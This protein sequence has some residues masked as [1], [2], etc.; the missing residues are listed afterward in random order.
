MRGRHPF[1]QPAPP[2][3][4]PLVHN[5]SALNVHEYDV[6][7]VCS[8]LFWRTKRELVQTFFE[9]LAAIGS[10]GFLAA[11]EVAVCEAASASLG[12]TCIVSQ[13]FRRDGSLSKER[14]RI[15]LD[16]L[17]RH[18]RIMYAGLDVRF[19]QPVSSWMRAAGPEVADAVFE[20]GFNMVTQTVGEFTPD[21]ALLH[22]SSITI[23]LLER[24]MVALQGRSLVGLP[25]FL[26]EASL[27]RFNL[28]GPAE[29]DLLRDFLLS[30]L[31]N[32]TVAVRKYQIARG[33]AASYRVGARL[34]AGVAVGESGELPRCGSTWEARHP[35]W[36]AACAGAA[37]VDEADLPYRLPYR[38]HDNGVIVRGSGGLRVFLSNGVG[39]RVSSQPCRTC[40]DW[41]VRRTMAL[42]CLTKLPSCLN[43][44]LCSCLWPQSQGA[45]PTTRRGDE[46]RAR[47][48]RRMAHLRA[49]GI[50][51]GGGRGGRGP[52]H[53]PP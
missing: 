14:W 16:I 48:Q 38:V 25:A 39:L 51:G 12:L 3:P 6:F 1:R 13:T 43:L 46:T 7:A 53:L 37:I 47:S 44:S 31:Y 2:P 36:R 26:Q 9:H 11:N 24:L 28:M 42:H 22:P 41:D 21:L 32:R 35:K 20:G 30:S 29:Q 40:S 34:G 52:R 8:S 4:L 27:L 17:R 15:M 45:D 18:H 33:G 50:G 5:L 19:L 49:Y 10:R 23:G